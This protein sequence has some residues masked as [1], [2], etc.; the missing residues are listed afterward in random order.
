MMDYHK[1]LIKD[2]HKELMKDFKKELLEDAQKEHLKFSASSGR[3]PAEAY[4]AF[5]QELPEGNPGNIRK[6]NS[7]RFPDGF[8]WGFTE[9][10][11]W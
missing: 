3:F 7:W 1:T 10:S 4:A 11:P 8:L 2:P 9:G 5:S 6:R